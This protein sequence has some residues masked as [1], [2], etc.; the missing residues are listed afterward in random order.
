MM[1][2]GI[3]YQWD[4]PDIMVIEGAGRLEYMEFENDIWLW[5]VYAERRGGGATLAR[6]FIAYAKSV[7]KNIYGRVEPAENV[8]MMDQKRL[9]R[10]YKLLGCKPIYMKDNPTAMKLEVSK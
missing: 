10:L 6:K 3:E 5:G 1:N 9:T 4:K 7:G 8:T 2:K